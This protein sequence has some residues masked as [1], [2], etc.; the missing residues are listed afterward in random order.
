MTDDVGDFSGLRNWFD[1]YLNVSWGV[2][3]P[4]ISL[5][6]LLGG[7]FFVYTQTLCD[8]EY[9]LPLMPS[10]P[11]MASPVN[12][13]CTRLQMD[14][15]C[16]KIRHAWQFW[17]GNQCIREYQ[18]TFI[19]ECISGDPM[20]DSFALIIKDSEGNVIRNDFDK[21]WRKIIW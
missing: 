17:T 13:N 15:S 18:P 12:Y 8:Y 3:I 2:A 4:V 11:L 7:G 10:T 1:K 9:D 14:Y 21:G 19:T 6:L 5:S 16:C 20:M